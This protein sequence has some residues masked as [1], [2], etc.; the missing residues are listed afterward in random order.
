MGIKLDW[1]VESDAGRVHVA[2][3]PEIV[4][5]TRRR[6]RGLQVAL[7]VIVVVVVGGYITVQARLRQIDRQLEENLKATIA[8]ETLALRIG[9]RTAF[10]KQQSS[11][12]G[13]RDLQQYNFE[14]YISQSPDIQV[15]G[16]ILNLEITGDEALVELAVETQDGPTTAEWVYTHTSSGWRH[17]AS[18]D[19]PWGIQQTEAEY[20]TLLYDLEQTALAEALKQYLNAVWEAACETTACQKPP[21]LTVNLVNRQL[22]LVQWNGDDEMTVFS[23]DIEPPLTDWV[24]LHLDRELAAYWARDVLGPTEWRVPLWAKVELERWLRFTFNIRAHGLAL[25]PYNP[26]INPSPLLYHLSAAFDTG[27]VPAWAGYVRRGE[28]ASD[29]LH[30]A[31]SDRAKPFTRDDELEQYLH[32]FLRAETYFRENYSRGAPVQFHEI[33]FEPPERPDPWRGQNEWFFSGVDPESVQILAVREMGD[34]I[35]AYTHFQI[36]LPDDRTIPRTAYFP[37]RF[38]G[39][40]LPRVFPESIDWGEMEH[41]RSQTAYASY[42]TVDSAV[43][44]STISSLDSMIDNIASDFGISEHPTIRFVIRPLDAPEVQVSSNTIHVYVASPYMQCCLSR[45]SDRERMELNAAVF[46]TSALVQ[47]AAGDDFVDLALQYVLGFWEAER[48]GVTVPSG[49]TNTEPDS[50]LLDASLAEFWL[51]GY[52]DELKIMAT[53]DAVESAYGSEGIAMLVR[54]G[55]EYRNLDTWLDE[56]LGIAPGEIEALWREKLATR[57]AEQRAQE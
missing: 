15:T 42:F 50:Q 37:F 52:S 47:Y 24:V 13:W 33:F 23:D 38:D 11:I 17:A 39:S 56:S 36:N 44:G 25:T 6:A 14:R 46:I 41:V 10:L 55:N 18:L 4:A 53:L 21:H 3:A 19:Q 48:L 26:S 22:S 8:A 20:I 54:H 43:V 49:W 29:A 27:I 30:A 1:Q 31:M 34:V 7:I 16:E 45:L 28:S 51:T 32:H 5:A 9:D 2:E 57:I 35:W 40:F 12:D